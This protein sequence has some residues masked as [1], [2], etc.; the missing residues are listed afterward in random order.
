MTS[1]IYAQLRWEQLKGERKLQK[2]LR[3][4]LGEYLA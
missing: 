1:K 3:T 2:C 4:V